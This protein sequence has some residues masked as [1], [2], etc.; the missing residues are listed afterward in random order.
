MEK[1]L[2]IKSIKAKLL[3]NFENPD[4]KLYLHKSEV[5]KLHKKLYPEHSLSQ[6][7]INR[8][9]NIFNRKMEI[10]KEIYSE[11]N[12]NERKKCLHF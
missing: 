9:K 3:H 12:R 4:I 6:V 1:S 7:K 11:R 2:I 8:I 5:E 10:L